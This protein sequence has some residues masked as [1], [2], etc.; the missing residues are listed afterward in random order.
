[1]SGKFHTRLGV[2]ILLAAAGASEAS[3]ASMGLIQGAWAM[4][5]AVCSEIFT[6]TGKS[7]RFKDRKSLT[8]N[9]IIVAGDKILGPNATCTAKRIRKEGNHLSALLSCSDAIIF[10]TVSVSFRLIDPEHF[11]HFDPNFPDISFAYRKC[12]M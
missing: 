10:G 2:V 12:P 4:D 8:N 5:G 9:G 11:E 1:M 7:L 3:A 6:G